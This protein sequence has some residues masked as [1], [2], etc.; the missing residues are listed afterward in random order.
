MH[1]MNDHLQ[2]SNWLNHTVTHAC[3]GKDES[4]NPLSFI[5]LTFID[6]G[7]NFYSRL[8]RLRLK[9]FGNSCLSMLKH[10]AKIKRNT[11]LLRT[12]MPC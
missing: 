12:R 7:P 1:M 11:I 2:T 5:Q 10:V 4:L 3:K 6:V 8:E 9:E